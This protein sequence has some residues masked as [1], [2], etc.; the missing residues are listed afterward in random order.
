VPRYYFSDDEDYDNNTQEANTP[1][2]RD[3]E[4]MKTYMGV[5]AKLYPRSLF[6]DVHV[7][8]SV[9]DKSKPLTY[10]VQHQIGFQSEEK[11]RNHLLQA[12]SVS[13]THPAPKQRRYQC[14][15]CE[16]DYS[17]KENR[18]NHFMTAHRGMFHQCTHCLRT[19]KSKSGWSRHEQK[20]KESDT[21]GKEKES[22]AEESDEEESDGE[23]PERKETKKKA[24]IT[25]V[26]KECNES[27]STENKLNEHSEV[28]TAQ[29]CP[30]CGETFGSA[31]ETKNHA[32]QDCLK[33][34]VVF[35]RMFPHK[36]KIC[37]DAF[38]TKE[39]YSLHMKEKHPRGNAFKCTRCG[40]TITSRT[41]ATKH[42]E[43][44]RA[45]EKETKN[46]KT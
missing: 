31:E 25:F 21:K 22:E 12:H 29:R 30:H 35:N 16:K 27:F 44:C 28:H 45:K 15:V 19:F 2:K 41:E 13:E 8:Q 3:I 36:C 33:N 46:R 39:E 7:Q 17:T 10:C 14:Q 42:T 11:Y 20:C 34:S 23:K 4:Q 40:A 26:C 37:N 5:G 43:S 9:V 18:D 38:T 6:G 1:H 24:H 32:N